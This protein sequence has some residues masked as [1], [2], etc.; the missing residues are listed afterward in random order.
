[1]K[2]CSCNFATIWIQ[3]RTNSVWNIKSACVNHKCRL[4]W[5]QKTSILVYKYVRFGWINFIKYVCIEETNQASE[6]RYLCRERRSDPNKQW[7]HS[8]KHTVNWWMNTQLIRIFFECM[9]CTPWVYQTW[10]GDGTYRATNRLVANK[11]VYLFVCEPTCNHW[12]KKNEKQNKK[13]RATATQIT[14][15]L[16]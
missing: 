11:I 1:M 8:H 4:H 7:A 5:K 3:S 14:M 16:K 6:D 10:F 12:W 15:E 13:T 9:E 2:W